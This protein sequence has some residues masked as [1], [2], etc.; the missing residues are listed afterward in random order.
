MQCP[1]RSLKH[2]NPIPPGG[3]L[4][5]SDRPILP[6]CESSICNLK[7][8]SSPQFQTGVAKKN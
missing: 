4:E 3:W 8:A 2:K 5:A 7:T 6:K 1:V